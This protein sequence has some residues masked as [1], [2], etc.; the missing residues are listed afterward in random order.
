[1]TE[2]LADLQWL[3]SPAA[4][5]AFEI[6]TG[7][8]SL[9]AISARL[10]KTVTAERARLVVAQT[11]LR[12]KARTKFLLHDRLFFTRTG[13]EQS[14]DEWIARY[15]AGRFEQGILIADLCCGLGGDLMAL[16]ARGPVV[17]IDRDPVAACFAKANLRIAN[18]ARRSAHDNPSSN[19]DAQTIVAEVQS[20]DLRACGAW[21]L[22]PDRRP[23]GRRTTRVELH[24]PSLPTIDGFLAQN[25]NAAIK[26]APG[27]DPP[28]AWLA[29][30]EL[31]WVARAGE[32]RQL[33][34]WFGDLSQQPG[35]RRA[36]VLTGDAAVTL[37]APSS[38]A[39]HEL[40]S[41]EL[42]E[43]LFDPSAAVLAASLLP[44]LANEHGLAS[45]GSGGAYLTGNLPIESALMSTF[46]VREVLP[47]ETKSLRQAL[48]AR[49]IGTLEIKKRVVDVS[50]EKLRQQLRL[51]GSESATLVLANVGGR[52]TAILA[53]RL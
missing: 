50:P 1:M 27:C 22:D 48:A 49:R 41:A 46:R 28:A 40:P 44:T 10:R 37:Y 17:G 16:G 38:T 5:D 8:D 42:G 43:Y 39:M 36:T 9:L 31:E 29:T 19:H 4:Y 51:A 26:L 6:A 25:A 47:M 30:A 23:S 13:L 53:D 2:S 32:C 18:T 11:E 14:T 20:I 24:E 45:L 12:G 3:T 21:H 7:C 52:P 35:S 15:K 33:I 34:A